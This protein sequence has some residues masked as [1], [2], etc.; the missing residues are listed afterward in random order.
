MASS[1]GAASKG[2]DRCARCDDNAGSVLLTIADMSVLEA[3][4]EVDE[5]EIPSVSLGQQAK[6][7]IDAVPDRVQGPRNRGRQQSDSDHDA[8]PGSAAGDDLQGGDA[9]GRSA[10][11][12]AWIHL[13]QPNHDREPKN[14]VSVPIQA[15]TVREMLYNDRARWCANS[16][17]AVGAKRRRDARSRRPMSRLRAHPKDR[18]SL[19]RLK[20]TRRLHAGEGRHP[21]SSTSRCSTA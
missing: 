2:R 12:A 21:A 1:P 5:T 4:V 8:E 16:R 10:R 14:V 19:C 3:E 13:S 17:S 6:V 9:R 15:L 7:T 20:R 11:C 18:G